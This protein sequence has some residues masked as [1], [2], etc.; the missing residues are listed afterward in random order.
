MGSVFVNN[1]KSHND[2]TDYTPHATM[3]S[4]HSFSPL[5][6][7]INGFSIAD[8]CVTSICRR[9][10]EMRELKPISLSNNQTTKTGPTEVVQFDRASDT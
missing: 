6:Y 1:R 2:Y 5:A 7:E 9:I 4:V 8:A 10:K 3:R